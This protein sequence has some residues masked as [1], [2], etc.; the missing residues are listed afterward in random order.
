MTKINQNKGLK[1]PIAAATMLTTVLDSKQ[2]QETISEAKVVLKWGFVVLGSVLVGKYVWS[3]YK[4]IRANNYARQNAGNPHVIA[5]GVIYE[6]FSRF[7]KDLG[8]LSWFLP[9]INIYTNETA[10]NNI[11]LQIKDV[12]LV[13]KA[14]K[15]LFDRELF[16]DIRKGLSTSEMKSFWNRINA[17]DQNTSSSLYAIGDNLYAAFKNGISVNQA[18]KINGVWKGTKELYDNFKYNDFIGEIIDNGEY[19][20]T[21]D[22]KLSNGMFIA[23]GTKVNYYIV[24]DYYWLSF[25]WKKGVVIQPQASNKK[26]DL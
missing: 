10:L 11:A 20:Y 3:K 23:A 13:S 19:L 25:K 9:E 22:T 26:L 8:L 17:K 2:G 14:Y 16:T 12:K 6:S 1:N 5:A 18:E 7:G 15:I 4:D 21:E 24:E